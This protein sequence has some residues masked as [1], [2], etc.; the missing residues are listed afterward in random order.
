MSKP[1]YLFSTSPH[2]DAISVNSLEI[3]LLKPDINFSE[4]DYMIITSKQA[5]KALQQY[6]SSEYVCKKALCVSTQTA[7]SYED[8]GGVILE[9]GDGYGDALTSK[10]KSYPR[11][12]KWLYLRAKV[13]ASDFVEVCKN[14]GYDIS[15]IVAYES[16]CS[17]D[18]LDIK[19]DN[20]SVLIFTSPS[21][22]KCYLKRHK[23]NELDMVI[24]IGKTTGKALPFGVSYRV[25]QNASIDSCFKLLKDNYKLT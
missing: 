2:P 1:M 11:N 25:S 13:V 21:S 5:S 19:V 7:K 17:Q 18:I 4:Y 23:I 6:D 9:V 24:V 3:T 20:G 12:T 16:K 14:D 10:I 22:V 15:E 8:L